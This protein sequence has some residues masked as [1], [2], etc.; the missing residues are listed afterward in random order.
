MNSAHLHLMLNHIPVPRM[1]FGLALLGW[2]LLRKGEELKRTSLGLFIII[3]LLAIPTYLTGEPAEE[4]VENLSGVDKASIG[5]F[6]IDP[7]LGR[8]S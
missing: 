8:T 6:R 7:G 5:R 4:L 1:A 3:A 2:A